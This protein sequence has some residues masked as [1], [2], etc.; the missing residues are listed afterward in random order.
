M[1]SKSTFSVEKDCWVYD[2]VRK[3]YCQTALFNVNPNL[4]LFR[5]SNIRHLSIELPFKSNMW[6]CLPTLNHLHSLGVST[7]N[8]NNEVQNQLQ[9]LLNKAPN[10]CSLRFNCLFDSTT[11]SVL[12][13]ISSI[14]VSHLDLH[15]YVANEKQTWFNHEQCLALGNSLFGSRCEMLQ[16]MVENPMDV[17]A[18]IYSMPKL[19]ALNIQVFN[20]EGLQCL[21]DSLDSK[22]TIMRENSRERYIHSWIR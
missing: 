11:D 7:H 4:S 6:S 16:I 10:F 12:S 14:S 2:A 3:L 18:L 22:C 21:K 19:R 13:I 1:Q 5:F 17:L 15:N 20:D 8:D 9:T